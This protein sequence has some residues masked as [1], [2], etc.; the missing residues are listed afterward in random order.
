MCVRVFMTWSRIVPCPVMNGRLLK[1]NADVPPVRSA[2]LGFGSCKGKGIGIE[3]RS[4]R[5]HSFRCHARSPLEE[6][7]MEGEDNEPSMQINAPYNL[8]YSFTPGGLLVPYY[9]G[10]NY[11]L[12]YA[13]RCFE[14]YS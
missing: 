1:I 3:T 12:M 8:G 4:L 14:S 6:L 2:S 13:V 7:E 9:I 10:G 11:G 5:S